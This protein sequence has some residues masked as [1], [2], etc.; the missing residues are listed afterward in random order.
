MT[1]AYYY[2]GIQRVHNALLALPV[3]LLDISVLCGTS[4]LVSSCVITELNKREKC[5]DWNTATYHYRINRGWTMSADLHSSLLQ[6]IHYSLQ[7]K[8][9]M[10]KGS[11]FNFLLIFP[12]IIYLNSHYRCNQ[13]F[14]NS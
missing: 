7:E 4:G 12:M 9:S 6:S 10:T 3:N 5:F 2:Y 13:F 11:I 14:F 1:S 8:D